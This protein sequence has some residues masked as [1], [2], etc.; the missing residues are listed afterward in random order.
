[1]GPLLLAWPAISAFFG[2]LWRG[3]V[4][5]IATPVGA[6]LVAGL[7]LYFVGSITTARKLNHEWKVKWEQAENEAEAARVLRDANI[8]REMSANANTRLMILDARK[9][10]LEQ[11]V[12][13]YE[14][15]EKCTGTGCCLTDQ[16]DA[17]WLSDIRARPKGP[18]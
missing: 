11:K 1:M 6:A 13:E 9:R 14:S 10:D 16:S 8:K 2:K 17:D 7:L 15:T 4:A 5:I 18:R 12:K 3:F